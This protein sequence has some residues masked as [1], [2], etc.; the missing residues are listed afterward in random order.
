MPVY[1]YDGLTTLGIFVLKMED[2]ISK[3][4]VVNFVIKKL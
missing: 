1:L 3:T 4:C 2:F